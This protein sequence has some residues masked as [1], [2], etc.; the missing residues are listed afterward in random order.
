MLRSLRVHCNV[1]TRKSFVRCMSRRTKN[2]DWY[3]NAID[4]LAQEPEKISAYPVETLHGRK[5]M[6][7]FMDL[8]IGR[9][10]Q[11]LN[12]LILELTDDIV[13]MTVRNFLEV[14]IFQRP[15][16]M[17]VHRT[18]TNI[19]TFLSSLASFLQL[20]KR[21]IGQGYIG[22][23][24]FNVRKGF[25]I[26]G[27]DWVSSNGRGGHSSFPEKYF[28]DENFI[29]RHSEPGVITMAN[30]GVHSNSSVFSILLAKQP[31]L[32]GRNVAFGKVL[33]GMDILKKLGTVFTVNFKPV[34]P[35]I[36]HAIGVIPETEYAS[37][38]KQASN[39]KK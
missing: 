16:F 6:R 29:V 12:R 14:S 21:P 5:R 2:L 32:D 11:S 19:E 10:T 15:L 18:R 13:P 37:I 27:G 4:S 20:S 3:V 26:T 22:S 25:A 9:E 34:T 35:I 36:I 31:H 28:Q 30:A 17:F 24:F 7:V 1:E 8:K 33:V 38:D 39:E 23:E